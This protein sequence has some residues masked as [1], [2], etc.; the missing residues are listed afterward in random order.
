MV[1]LALIGAS[2]ASWPGARRGEQRRRTVEGREGNTVDV[3]GIDYR[4]TIFR[5][6]NPRIPPDRALLDRGVGGGVAGDDPFVAAFLTAATPA[7][8]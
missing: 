8:A 6:L 2:L 1:A 4:V 3:G 7:R 5:Q